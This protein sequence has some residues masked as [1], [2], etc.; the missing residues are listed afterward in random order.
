MNGNKRRLHL[1]EGTCK[2]MEEEIDGMI[3]N[4][5]LCSAIPTK[6]DEKGH[7]FWSWIFF[8]GHVI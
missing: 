7:V 4:S 1:N 6:C 3:Y 8:R 2:T 5:P